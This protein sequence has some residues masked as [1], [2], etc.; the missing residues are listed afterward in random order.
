MARGSASEH[1]GAQQNIC[2]TDVICHIV[3]G[4]G[5]K[6]EEEE[7]EERK[8]EKTQPYSCHN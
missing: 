1:R 2:S 7:R 3:K 8:K 6:E 5:K 4:R